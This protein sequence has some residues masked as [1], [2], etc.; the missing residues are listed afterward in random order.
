M[1]FSFPPAF[2]PVLWFLCVSPNAAAARDPHF[3][4]ENCIAQN[5][6][7]NSDLP[8]NSVR[9]LVQTGD[10]YI[11]LGTPAG[12]VRFD[13]VRFKVYSQWNTPDF[14]ESRILSLYADI[15]GT[16]W[17]GTDGGGL[18]AYGEGGWECFGEGEGVLDG[19]IR[20]VTGGLNGI[21]WAATEYGLH[22]FDGREIRVYGLDD[23]L[24]DDI[25][26]SLASDGFGCLWAGTMWGGLARFEDGLVQVYDFDDGLEDHRVLSLFADPGEGL[27]IGTMKGLFCLRPHEKVIRSIAGTDRYPVTAVAP[28]PGGLLLVGTMVEGLKIL[29]DSGPKNIFSDDELNESHIRA[30]LT[31]RDGYVWIGTE[32]RGL[33]QL[34]EKVVGSITTGTG[35]PEGSV[36]AIMEDADG[37]L[38]IGT[39]N[40]GLCRMRGGRI[41]RVSG[42]SQGIAGDMV[43]VLSRDRFGRLLVGTMDGGLSILANG[44]ID[45]LTTSE[46]LTSDNVT[47]ILH[48]GTGAVWVGTDRGLHRSPDG[49]VE[50]SSPI[51]DFEGRT[52]RTLYENPNGT[53]YIGTRSGLWKLSQSSFERVG[54]GGEKLELDVLSLHEDVEGGLWIGTN[55]GGL[56][57]LSGGKAARYTTGDG[58]PGNFIYS[59]E[60]KDSALLWISCEAGVFSINRDSLIAYSEGGLRIL[61]PTLYDDSDGMPSGRSNGYCAPAV[62][63]SV[64]G[65]WYYPTKAGIAVFER[66]RGRRK[67]RPPVVIVESIQ[68]GGV[69]LKT[70][71]FIEISH[72]WDRVEIRFTAFDYSAPGKCRFLYMLKG[73]DHGFKAL[74]PGRERRAV[75]EGL[76]PGE[77]EFTVRA[78]GNSRL[79]SERAASVDFVV[80]PPFYRTKAF[81]LVVI[82]GIA[83]TGGVSA[84]AARYRRIRKQKMKYSTS[85]IS[86]DRMEKAIALLKTLMEEER[87]FLDPDLSLKKLAQRLNIHYNHLSRII[88]ERYGMSFNNYINGFRIAEAQKRLADPSS[89]NENILNII[90]EVGF[91]S[92]S[93]FNAAFRR[94]TGMSPSEYRKKHR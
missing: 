92:K 27:W 19:H 48:S 55:G 17:A 3:I 85:S 81:L 14:K 18:Y 67:A 56:G 33:I 50:N 42:R 75:Y 82:A 66:K 91:Y 83:L 15:N 9:A 69:E 13:G 76:S 10:G 87:L 28:G 1:R 65:K 51:A 58:L 60:E 26:T 31:D 59:I 38:W 24:A 78:I 93:T 53:L 12:L 8:A 72:E 52:I 49:R 44:R 71:G 63:K 89:R 37:T 2:L 68:A 32:S 43:R 29:D 16:I 62:C 80:L 36:Y 6:N 34:R 41:T 39:E 45:N 64:S 46:G 21:L 22:R 79:W 90:Y 11:W 70:D 30:I 47:A 35:L 54:T 84:A 94:V 88:N 25:V 86:E 23:G 77:Y 40:S 61:A 7:T 4:P 74:H 20:A 73:C 57:L 5:W